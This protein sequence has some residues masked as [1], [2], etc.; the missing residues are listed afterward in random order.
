MKFKNVLILLCILICE[1]TFSQLPEFI[2]PQYYQ[3]GPG[4]VSSITGFSTS[5][6]TSINSYAFDPT[7]D[8]PNFKH[9][10]QNAWYDNGKLVFYVISG[11]D[12][13]SGSYL[14]LI[15]NNNGNLIDQIDKATLNEIGIVKVGC[16]SYH[17]LIGIT[18]YYLT[19]EP[20]LGKSNL[21]GAYEMFN[22]PFAGVPLGCT[23]IHPGSTK[24]SSF[25]SFAIS[26][27]R[28]SSNPTNNQY[29]I[30]Y[31]GSA[32]SGANSLSTI[33]EVIIYFNK[34]KAIAPIFQ[35]FNSYNT[36]YVDNGYK[37][38][39]VNPFRYSFLGEMELSPDQSKIAFIDENSVNI[40]DINTHAKYIYNTAFNY[41]NNGISID[42]PDIFPLQPCGLEFDQFSNQ[43]AIS[44]HDFRGYSFWP[45]GKDAILVWSQ[46]P[47]TPAVTFIYS[48]TSKYAN[49]FI[50][51][52]ID[53]HWYL[54]GPSFSGSS[55]AWGGF[56]KL[57]PT[58]TNPPTIGQFSYSS[59]LN[60]S[61]I[62]CQQK[63]C[64]TGSLGIPT[65]NH[66]RTLPNQIDGL[67]YSTLNNFDCCNQYDF[68]ILN[69]NQF[70]KFLAQYIVNTNTTF[71]KSRV[72]Y[73][74][75]VVK[76]GHS[77]TI[78]NCVIR[79]K[80][81]AKITVEAGAQLIIDNATLTD[82]CNLLWP[83]IVIQGSNNPVQDITIQGFVHLINNSIIEHA[84]QAVLVK[85]NAIIYGVGGSKILNCVNGVF[86]DPSASV[87][88]SWS[89]FQDMTF[90]CTDLIP[91]KTNGTLTFLGIYGINKIG[92]YGCT[93][94]NSAPIGTIPPL[95][96]GVG[97]EIM[98]SS[99]GFHKSHCIFNS[100]TN[101]W[102]QSG[103]SNRFEKL[104]VGI[105]AHNSGQNV[106]ID[107]SNFSNCQKSVYFT[108][109][110]ESFIIRSNFELNNNLFQIQ[111]EPLIS[112][113]EDNNT[114]GL[115]ILQNTFTW[116]NQ[117]SFSFAGI[118]LN[119]LTLNSFDNEIRNNSFT[120]LNRTVNTVISGIFQSAKLNSLKV[121]LNSFDKLTYGWYL[122]QYSIVNHQTVCLNNSECPDP[123][124]TWIDAAWSLLRIN[125]MSKPFNYF[126]NSTNR[127][128]NFDPNW[129]VFSIG[130]TY[131]LG[132]GQ[133]ASNHIGD[134]NLPILDP[135]F[136]AN[137]PYIKGIGIQISPNPIQEGFLNYS[138]SNIE[139]IEEITI[140]N[141]EGN[142]VYNELTT[143]LS[144]KI[145]LNSLYLSKGIY[146]IQFKTN[147]GVYNS[148]FIKQ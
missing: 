12:N 82:E 40:Y 143:N 35:N 140:I 71:E 80:E 65:N 88:D 64:Q 75:I 119:N 43:L 107:N 96:R 79:F 61:Q 98:N 85:P 9:F 28:F 6:T 90:E 8:F 48:N 108:G 19:L 14:T 95:S 120:Q 105:F 58:G 99:V 116:D 49:S 127:F 10:G 103:N 44:F 129:G 52:G 123:N 20:C 39:L 104:G 113:I 7:G 55:G 87:P 73:K 137:K 72:M 109:M 102:V 22:L 5:L 91:T 18:M 83:G 57:D 31:F 53:N 132:I 16:T 67:D 134:C 21:G 124:N 128:T 47:N 60:S 114:T 11:I 81:N 27:P 144:G 23:N 78:K 15:Y 118:L 70:E 51:N 106:I 63:S 46:F 26:K 145:N 4:N 136:S 126:T 34:P 68:D 133:V 24:L 33:R 66:F 37:T 115:H 86:F 130:A 29:S 92:V 76:S 54:L 125:N 62:D 93:F 45:T 111:F 3:G 32:S 138:L 141:T 122:D 89:F 146:N 97:V 117:P 50:E 74:D 69:T 2:A 13:S 59:E 1:K 94:K 112:F 147:N 42:C 131:N 139:S 135:I 36:D 142:V 38:T 110:G 100:G 84:V 30:Y 121:E 101:C 41:P 17:L 77:L 25:T 148:K 56:L